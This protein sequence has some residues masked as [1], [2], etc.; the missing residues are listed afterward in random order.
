MGIL[1]VILFFTLSAWALVALFRR[2]RRQQASRVLWFALSVLVA[3][4][5]AV[6]VWCA[7]SC[8]Y[9]VGAHFRVGSF[10]IPIVFFHFEDGQW[11]DFPVPEFQACSAVITNIVTITALATLP[12]WLV[13]W[14]QRRDRVA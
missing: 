1:I 4:G 5:I 12:I 2:L 7:F 6:G 11:V 13:S 3:C 8:E 9:Q 14:R 10:P